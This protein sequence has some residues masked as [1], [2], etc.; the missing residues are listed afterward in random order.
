MQLP[1]CPRLSDQQLRRRC[2]EELTKEHKAEP[3]P[4]GR[5]G[6]DCACGLIFK[7]SASRGVRLNGR[8]VRFQEA[9][10]FQLLSHPS[11]FRWQGFERSDGRV[12]P[13]SN[14]R[15][16]FFFCSSFLVQHLQR[17][18]AFVQRNVVAGYTLRTEP[19][20]HEAHQHASTAA[21]AVERTTAANFR[22]HKVQGGSALA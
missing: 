20:W 12:Q 18:P 22:I 19:L 17:L 11:L 1:F 5:A 15:T 6:Q 16:K 10:S 14:T 13:G 2:L 7:F 4:K 21:A 3:R 8:Q 9:R